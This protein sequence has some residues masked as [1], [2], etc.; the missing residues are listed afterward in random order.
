[1]GQTKIRSE[2]TDI[3]T[4]V[5]TLTNKTL[6]SPKI[7]EDVALTAN[8][9]ELNLLDNQTVLRKCVMGSSSLSATT[10]G[11]TKYYACGTNGDNA[12]EPS[13]VMPIAGTIKNLK[14]YSGGSPGVSQ[15]Y[16]LT[17][18]KNNSAQTVTCTIGEGTNTAA[19]TTHSF[20]VAAGDRV[21]LRVVASASATS[22]GINFAFEF[23]PS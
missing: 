13:Y 1:M 4:D 18:M 14:A 17:L 10:A 6:T 11:Q 22:T 15:T 2:Q 5:M 7:N 23:D 9:T 20:T 8:S 3:A 16:T 12:Y 19:D 21:S